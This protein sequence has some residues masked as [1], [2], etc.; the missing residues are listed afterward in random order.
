MFRHPGERMSVYYVETKGTLQ[1]SAD[2]PRAIRGL[3][4]TLPEGVVVSSFRSQRAESF[5]KGIHYPGGWFGIS[6]SNST[7]G[8]YATF[9]YDS[10]TPRATGQAHH[11]RRL[12]PAQQAAAEGH[13]DVAWHPRQHGDHRQSGIAE[14]DPGVL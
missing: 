11:A 2:K 13:R 4:L 8:A 7:V 10:Q 3:S 6:A 14:R 1:T 9:T 12:E 5:A